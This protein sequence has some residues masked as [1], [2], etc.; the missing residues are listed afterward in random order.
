M[1]GQLS[2]KT[3]SDNGL[4]IFCENMSM[5]HIFWPGFA[6]LIGDTNFCFVCV[7][8]YIFTLRLL[9]LMFSHKICL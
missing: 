8:F 4:T 6:A 2:E 5:C 7:P 9:F 1:Y 3:L